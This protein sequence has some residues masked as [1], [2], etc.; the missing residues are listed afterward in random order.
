MIT[1][2]EVSH[3]TIGVGIYFSCKRTRVWKYGFL[4]EM[5]VVLE[6]SPLDLANRLLLSH[7]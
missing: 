2:A 6:H 4:S 7:E 5:G 3:L 1:D